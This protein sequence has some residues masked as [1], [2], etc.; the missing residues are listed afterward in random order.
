MRKISEFGFIIAE[1]ILNK[2]L[3]T[4]FG[5]PDIFQILHFNLIKA[6]IFS[7]YVIKLF[8][9]FI[10]HRLLTILFSVERISYEFKLL[11]EI[12]NLNTTSIAARQKNQK[13]F[14]LCQPCK[15][16]IHSAYDGL[17]DDNW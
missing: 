14:S 4:F 6:I 13:D 7:K 12:V 1:N 10:I 3:F 11:S 8:L 2:K 17:L 16:R 15:L 9:F 5:T